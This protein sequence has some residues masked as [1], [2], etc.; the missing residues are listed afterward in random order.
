MKIITIA[1]LLMAVNLN[2]QAR[3]VCCPK[4]IAC[5]KPQE[6]S[7]PPAPDAATLEGVLER[8]RQQTNTL[9]SLEANIE[10]LFIEDP[11]LMDSRTLQK[12]KF[13]FLKEKKRYAI[14]INF[15]RRKQDDEDEY[16]DIVQIIFDGV[17]LIRIDHELKTVKYDQQA[18]KDKPIEAFEFINR[19]FPMIG[20]TKTEEL[21]KNFDIK[22]L[23]NDNDPNKPIH[24][25]LKPKAGS[26]YAKEYCRLNFWIDKKTFLPTRLVTT[27][28][29]DVEGEGN[30]YDIKLKEIRANKKIEK[31][32]FKVET[33]TGFAEDRRLLEDE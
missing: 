13:Y 15:D 26:K 10:Y 21:Q 20:F 24:L 8:L 29:A 14:R 22:M 17:W 16:K 4:K 33:P 7:K 32:V 30:I 27:E 19:N 5:L 9:T 18:E 28:F 11:M 23:E 25:R 31:A 1:I 6:I 12:G 2:C 3:Q